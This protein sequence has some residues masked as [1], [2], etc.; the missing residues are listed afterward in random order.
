MS[1]QFVRTKFCSDEQVILWMSPS[2]FLWHGNSFPTAKV[3]MIWQPLTI[4]SVLKCMCAEF[5]GSHHFTPVKLQRVWSQVMTPCH[6]IKN[7]KKNIKICSSRKNILIVCNTSSN[8]K[9]QNYML[10]NAVL[11]LQ[12]S[13]DCISLFL[14]YVLLQCIQLVLKPRVPRGIV[15]SPVQTYSRNFG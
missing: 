14:S 9:V 3:H 2:L 5:S 8:G 1:I 13:N 15:T 6:E 10:F 4:T 11:L 7:Y 12:V